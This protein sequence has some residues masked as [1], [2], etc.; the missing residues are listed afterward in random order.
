MIMILVQMTLDGLVELIV[1][2]NKVKV[3]Q[4]NWIGKSFGCEIAF[5][6]EGSLPVKEIK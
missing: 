3:M 1:W 5:Q 4:K 2:P 6:T